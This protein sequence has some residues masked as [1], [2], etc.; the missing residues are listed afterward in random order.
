M[1]VDPTSLQ[2]ALAGDWDESI[3]GVTDGQLENVDP[4][5]PQNSYFLACAWISLGDMLNEEQG[6]SNLQTES[7]LAV[8]QHPSVPREKEDRAFR[9]LLSRW[10]DFHELNRALNR[11]VNMKACPRLLA[12]YH[13]AMIESA[14]AKVKIGELSQ[15]HCQEHFI[16]K[17]AEALG[18]RRRLIEDGNDDDESRK[19]CREV[20]TKNFTE[21]AESILSDRVS[22][23]PEAVRNSAPDSVF[24]I[25]DATADV[26]VQFME[27]LNKL[28]D[29]ESAYALAIK[30]NADATST[31]A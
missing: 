21:Q 14:G 3:E 1:Y 23:L 19:V 4:W 28:G 29:I 7:I 2:A 13:A 30:S 6:F 16:A 27:K 10:F 17:N 18:A 12:K 5:K 15:E 24:D 20:W 31:V 25:S 11:Q 26:T 22:K 9:H 8:F